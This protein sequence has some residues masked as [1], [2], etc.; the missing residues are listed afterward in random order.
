MCGVDCVECGRGAKVDDDT[1]RSILRHGCNRIDNPV[2]TNVCGRIIEN[3]HTRIHSV[4]DEQWLELK[5]SL[6]HE[7]E[8][9]VEGRHYR[10][11]HDSI[12]LVEMKTF[13]LKEILQ[14]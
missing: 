12:D 7:L 3:L 13:A 8:C 11:D 4:I 5:A 2:R 9:L 6:A 10:R 14:I 1:R